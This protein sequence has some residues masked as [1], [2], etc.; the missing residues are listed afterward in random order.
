[1]GPVCD[2]SHTEFL[3]RGSSVISNPESGNSILLGTGASPPWVG[4]QYTGHVLDILNLQTFDV[5]LLETKHMNILGIILSHFTYASFY[6]VMW[7]TYFAGL[8]STLHSPS[9]SLLG[10][11]LALSFLFHHWCWHCFKKD[12][13]RRP[14]KMVIRKY[15]PLMEEWGGKMN[16]TKIFDSLD[17]YQGYS[18]RVWYGMVSKSHI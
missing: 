5:E 13:R 12:Y 3:P 15:L 4:K 18:F 16:Q 7:T 10:W 11:A 6:I 2:S 14:Q 8:T 1:M 17:H 9:L